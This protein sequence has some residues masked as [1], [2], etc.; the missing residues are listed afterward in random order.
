MTA[1]YFDGRNSIWLLAKN[2]PAS[3]LRKYAWRI[4]ARQTWLAW[5]ALKAWRGPEARARLRGMVSGLLT[6][7]GALKKRRRV[8]AMKRVSDHYL[9]NMLTRT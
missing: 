6:L 9:D 3:L 5:S 8:Q 1:S 4:L 2:M 7:R